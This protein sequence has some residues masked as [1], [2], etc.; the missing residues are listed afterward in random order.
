MSF[1]KGFKYLHFEKNYMVNRID[2]LYIDV[3]IDVDIYQ[4]YLLFD[5]VQ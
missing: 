1:E 3:D 4:N 2:Y 5:S